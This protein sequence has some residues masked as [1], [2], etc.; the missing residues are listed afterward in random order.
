MIL[1]IIDHLSNDDLK[2][3]DIDNQLKVIVTRSKT[4][5]I[6]TVS[7]EAKIQIP[8]LNTFDDVKKATELASQALKKIGDVLGK[9]SRVIHVFAKK[10]AQDLKAH[11]ASISTSHVSILRLVNNYTKFE[12]DESLIKEKTDKIMDVN[13]I[14][15]DKNAQIGRASCRER[16]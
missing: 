7:K 16:V 5:I 13:Q 11:L 15:N 8:Q 2:V 14:I 12:S 10:Y 1:K 3:D 9:N 4:E 6:N